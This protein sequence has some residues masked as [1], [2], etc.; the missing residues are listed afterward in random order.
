MTMIFGEGGPADNT[1]ISVATSKNRRIP[2]KR[3]SERAPES[4]FAARQLHEKG[5][6]QLR[7]LRSDYNCV[8]MV[9]ANR[10]TFI[11]P[12]HIP[13][14]LEDDQYAEVEPTT[15]TP[16]DVVVYK[17]AKTA[18]IIHVG[19]VISVEGMF[20]TKKIRV[21]S[22]F[23]RDGEYFHDATDIPEMYTAHGPPIIKFYSESRKAT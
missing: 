12:D 17:H 15:V 14:I 13:M 21:L 6:R 8:G 11:E 10:R 19:M 2:N 3:M 18:D 9:F 1:S 5:S 16:G 7:S 20:E 22:Q 23:G 4:R